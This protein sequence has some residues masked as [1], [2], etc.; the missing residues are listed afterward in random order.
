ME[1]ITFKISLNSVLFQ[2]TVHNTQVIFHPLANISPIWQ[3][4]KDV[5]IPASFMET[6]NC[7][8]DKHAVN[9][10]QIEAMTVL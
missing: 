2:L 1:Y 3:N 8:K 4:G 9:P 5:Q 7:A 6:D 10:S